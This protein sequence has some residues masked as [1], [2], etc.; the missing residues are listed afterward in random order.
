VPDPI[1]LPPG[2]PFAALVAV[3]VLDRVLALLRAR[4]IAG[5]VDEAAHLATGT[6]VLAAWPAPDRDFASGLAAGSVLIDVDHV[7][8]AVGIRL[9][10]RGTRPVTHSLSTIAAA[11]LAGRKLA[12]AGLL[13][14]AAVRGAMVGATCH[15]ARD[16][17]TGTAGVPLL[18]PLRG[19][20]FSMPYWIYLAGLT[21]LA[22][23]GSV[24]RPLQ[25]DGAVRGRD[26][27]ARGTGPGVQDHHEPAP[28]VPPQRPPHGA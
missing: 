6:I 28:R 24:R 7:P 10:R 17:T 27:G 3:L 21:V 8:D 19:R 18:W 15:L 22:A 23:R 16:L 9:L 14:R 2:A 1:E 25:L 11:G 20:S 12:A 26:Q 5:V 4:P 13:P